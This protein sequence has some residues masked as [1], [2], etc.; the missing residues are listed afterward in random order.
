M[1]NYGFRSEVD[2]LMTEDGPDV[3][4]QPIQQEIIPLLK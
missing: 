4:T 1:E 3:T 2:L